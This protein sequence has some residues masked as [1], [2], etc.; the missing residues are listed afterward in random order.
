MGRHVKR[1]PGMGCVMDKTI[2][3]DMV[4]GVEPVEVQP[5]VFELFGAIVSERFGLLI[6]G[7]A[8]PLL[9]EYLVSFGNAL[10]CKFHHPG[11]EG[12]GIIRPAL[13][14]QAAG[15]GRQRIDG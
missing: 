11:I 15:P 13:I 9:L 12:V 14:H 8:L 3:G 1:R 6:A 2:S 7:E 5:H 4:A 10:P